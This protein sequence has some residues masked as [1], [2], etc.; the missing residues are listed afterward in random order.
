MSLVLRDG[1]KTRV[2]PPLYFW[3]GLC[4]VLALH[5]AYPAADL[6]D[7]PWNLVGVLPLLLGIALN[8]LADRS[9]SRHG[10]TVKPYEESDRLIADGVF[11]ISRH[12]M[13][14]GMT[15]ILAGVATLLGSLSPFFAV[16]A[17]AVLVECVFIRLEETM[18]SKRFGDAW[19]EYRTH[20]HKWI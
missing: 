1:E 20:V 8:I 7:L 18:L 17:F 16:V 13:Y 6:L 5:V 15:L 10:T 2:L 4:A 12:P 19:D 14:L 3:T 11:R 9:F